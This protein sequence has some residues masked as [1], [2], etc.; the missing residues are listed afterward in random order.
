MNRDEKIKR[1]NVCCGLKIKTEFVI[2]INYDEEIKRK[3]SFNV[4]KG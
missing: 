4:A 3:I 1:K 2:I